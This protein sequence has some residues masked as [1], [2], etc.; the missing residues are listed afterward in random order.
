M[1]DIMGIIILKHQEITTVLQFLWD[2]F[3]CTGGKCEPSD[4]LNA[5]S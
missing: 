5:S 1:L 2:L 3:V 4:L